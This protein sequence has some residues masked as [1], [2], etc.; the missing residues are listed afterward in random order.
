[1]DNKIACA[2]DPS[3]LGLTLFPTE[4][5]NF[6]FTYCYEDYTQGRMSEETVEGVKNL[7]T[8]RAP[9]LSLLNLSW[10]GGESLLTK[11]I[12]IDVLSYAQRS[13]GSALYRQRRLMVTCWTK[14]RFLF[15]GS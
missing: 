5:C 8:M 11:D 13:M 4:K 15:W 9:D 1:M 3:Y 7:L 6:R 2:L 10:F 12:L 14:R